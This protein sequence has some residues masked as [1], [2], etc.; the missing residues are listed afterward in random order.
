MTRAS[1]RKDATQL[2]IVNSA[3]ASAGRSPNEEPLE[4]V[5]VPSDTVDVS[6]VIPI[7]NEEA[8]LHAAVVDLRERLVGVSWSYEI[9]LAENGSRDKTLEIAQSL[10]QKY[11]T[12]RAISIPEP[13]Y[14]RALREGI[15]AARGKYV[16]CDEIDLC[17]VDFQ[18]RAVELLES[19]SA[20]F[21]IGS[22]LIGGAKD[23]RPLFRHVAS[24]LYTQLLRLL[25][26]F[27]G[28]DTHGLKA[29]RRDAVLPVVR[30][31]VVD[32]DVFS[33]ELVIRADRTGLRMLEIPVRVKEKR[34]P[35]IN[36]VRR[37]PQVVKS[38]A[39]LT[40]AIRVVR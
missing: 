36:L 11:R 9:L 29:V 18:C 2:R 23:E 28:T 15:E 19:E 16:L 38:L 32:R 1:S 7:Y 37:I 30:S 26:G 3:G 25:L 12:V 35:S 17:D 6:I 39:R 21:V 20:D 24:Q 33:S 10:A 13:N 14:G 8:I 4:S 22:K 27:H 40:W 31:C 34:P 5:K